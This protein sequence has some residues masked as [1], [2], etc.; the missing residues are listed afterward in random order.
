[1]PIA[2][3]L[4]RGKDSLQ[5]CIFWTTPSFINQNLPLHTYT[6]THTHTYITR[7]EVGVSLRSHQVPA[8]LRRLPEMSVS[9]RAVQNASARQTLG[10]VGKVQVLVSIGSGLSSYVL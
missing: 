9:T 1:M 7:I 4:T 3:A 5:L 2:G 10:S 6:H 8:S